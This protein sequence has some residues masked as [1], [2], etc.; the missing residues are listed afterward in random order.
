MS[1]LIDHNSN[2]SS[3]SE[4]DLFSVPPTQVAIDG[5]YWHAAKLINTCTHTGPWEF[6]VQGDSHYLQ[7]SKN[8][9]YLKLK[10][11]RADGTDLHNTPAGQNAAADIDPVGTINLLGKT[12]FRQVKAYI[13]GKQAFD[14]GAMYAYKAFLETELNFGQAAKE[15]HLAAALYAKDTPPAEIDTANNT[16]WQA[17]KRWFAESQTVELMAPIHCDFFQ[18]EKLMLNHLDLRLELHRNGN[19]FCIQQTDARLY[20]LQVLDMVWY[21]KKVEVAKS[22]DLAIE[23]T[24]AHTPAKYPIRRVEMAKIHVTAGNNS[25]PNNNLFNGQIPRRLVFGCVS[26]ESYYGSRRHSPFKFGNY[27]IEQVKVMAGGVC[28]PREPLQMDFDTYAFVRPYIQLFEAIE[29]AKEDKGNN[30]TPAD[31]KENRCLFVFDLTPDEQDG[32]HWDLLRE[33]S[34]SIDIKFR[35]VIPQGQGIEVIVYAEF[36]NLLSVDNYRNF[37]FDY[38]T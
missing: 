17:T 2:P 10:I 3:K 37:F 6:V 8:Y 31:F 36:D 11:V 24:L 27:T 33:G 1:K 35:D 7:L 16:G 4:L 23:R 19:A 18:T 20:K 25:T 34:T 29:H 30:I 28:F 9:L 22:I 15:T 5:G 21:V 13:G 38:N 12:L 14:S 26:T 32:G